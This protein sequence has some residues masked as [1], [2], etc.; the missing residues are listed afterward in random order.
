MS[1]LNKSLVCGTIVV[2]LLGALSS[3]LFCSSV[4]EGDGAF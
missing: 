1:S 3:F 2:T 4:C